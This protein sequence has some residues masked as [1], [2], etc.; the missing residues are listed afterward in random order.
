MRVNI[1]THFNGVGLEHDARIINDLLSREG[2]E[3]KYIEVHR[4][5]YNYADV[6]IFLELV[7]IKFKKYGKRNIIIPNPEWFFSRWF[8]DIIDF[9][10]LCKTRD[11]MCIFTRWS[12]K[13]SYIGF[14]SEDCH[15]EDVYREPYFIHIAGKSSQKNTD[16][17]L[18]AWATGRIREKLIL[19]K[20]DKLIKI[21]N[22]IHLRRINRGDLVE[23]MNICKYHLCPSEYEG[24]GHYINEARSVG[25]LII[26]TNS[27]PMNEIVR[28]GVLIEPDYYYLR[29]QG[30]MAKITDVNKIIMAVEEVKLLG[31]EYMNKTR[32]DYLIDK[33]I[34]EK[35]F[36]KH[37]K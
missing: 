13:V 19:V 14:T 24:F 9:E 11:T 5:E 3:V 31:E 2:H 22:V 25:G 30:K 21:N 4:P 6:N 1:I 28:H 35:N 7:D 16:V 8:P 10:V 27:E 15:R 20:D 26:S 12:K 37:F 18:K 34:F 23:L 36:L 17:I 33:E 32:E 29:H